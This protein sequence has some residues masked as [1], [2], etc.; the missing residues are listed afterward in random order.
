M[1]KRSLDEGDEY[2]DEGDQNEN[3]ILR[4]FINLNEEYEWV[5]FI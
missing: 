5:G 1:K 3:M 4:G 2:V